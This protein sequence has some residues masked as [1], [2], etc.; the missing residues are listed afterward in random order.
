MS[1]VWR[2]DFHLVRIHV[3]EFGPLSVALARASRNVTYVCNVGTSLLNVS[4]AESLAFLVSLSRALMAS[5][6]QNVSE[7]NLYTC[8]GCCA[9]SC[10]NGGRFIASIAIIKTSASIDS[11]AGM[12][13]N[14]MHS[15]KSNSLEMTASLT[16]L[17]LYGCK[18]HLS[19]SHVH[20]ALYFSTKHRIFSSFGIA[21][22]IKIKSFNCNRLQSYE[23][24]D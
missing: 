17:S 20:G 8:S 23:I 18:S 3:G 21:S 15:S 7:P 12:R 14:E 24:E 10:W 9:P 19:M 22:R 13:I 1:K 2:R 5:P 11:M 4:G 6:M 16:H